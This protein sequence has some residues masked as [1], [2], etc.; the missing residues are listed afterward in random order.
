M[1]LVREC[2]AN[3]CNVCYEIAKVREVESGWVE[4]QIEREDGE[5][6]REREFDG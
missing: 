4:V 3:G 5:G 1:R 6:G 2:P